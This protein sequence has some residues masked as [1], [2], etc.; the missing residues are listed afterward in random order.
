MTSSGAVIHQSDSQNSGKCC[1]YSYS[2]IIRD[3]DQDQSKEEDAGQAWAVQAPPEEAGYIAPIP[4]TIHTWSCLE[5]LLGFCVGVGEPSLTALP[6]QRSKVGLIPRSRPAG[7]SS[8][9][10]PQQ[11]AFS[12]RDPPAPGSSMGLAA[13]SRVLGSGP[14]KV[15]VR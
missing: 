11:P 12:S 15:C 2:F 3:T 4:L 10:L 6:S 13:T 8:A 1:F 5:F 7:A 14:G 9:Q